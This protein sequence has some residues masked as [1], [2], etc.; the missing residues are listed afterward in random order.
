VESGFVK[1]CSKRKNVLG[2][3][4][5]ERKRPGGTALWVGGLAGKKAEETG[6]Y[7]YFH[8]EKREMKEEPKTSSRGRKERGC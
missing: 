4:I 1:P 2:F 3:V 6:R 7:Y 5:R 8:Q